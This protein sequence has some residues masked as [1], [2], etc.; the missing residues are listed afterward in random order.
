MEFIRTAR[1]VGNSAGILLPKQLLGSE[2]KIIVIKKPMNIKREVLKLVE[3]FLEDIQGIY[4]INKKPVEVLAATGKTRKIIKN[5]K[6]KISF[7]PVSIIRKDI[8][9]KAVLREKLSKAE[10]IMNGFLIKEISPKN[11][12]SS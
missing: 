7:V 11:S 10:V 2:V 4:V 6:V 3:P 5:E 8:K 12:A 9:E 1:N